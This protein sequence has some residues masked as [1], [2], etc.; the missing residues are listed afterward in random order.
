VGYACFGPHPLTEGAYDLY[1]IVVDPVARGNGVG[2]ALL[3]QVENEVR[4]RG[5]RL[6]LVET[7]GTSAYAAARHLYERGG[8]RREAIVHNFYAPG[9]DLLIYVKELQADAGEQAFGELHRAA[10]VDLFA[11]SPAFCSR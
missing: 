4:A 2:H 8:Y 6:L 11:E 5:G 3:R 10:S 9:D 7:S 1:W